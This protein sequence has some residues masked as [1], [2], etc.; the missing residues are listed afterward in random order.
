MST[1]TIAPAPLGDDTPIERLERAAGI[2]DVYDD[3]QAGIPLHVLEGRLEQMTAHLHEAG[4]S[5]SA[6]VFGYGAAVISFRLHQQATAAAQTTIA[7]EDQEN[8]Q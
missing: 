6:Y 8:G 2:A 5:Y 7:F 1:L 3:H 4:G